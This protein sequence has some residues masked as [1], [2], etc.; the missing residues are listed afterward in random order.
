MNT[1]QN[2]VLGTITQDHASDIA[3]VFGEKVASMVSDNDKPTT[4]LDLLVKSGAFD[5]KS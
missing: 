1:T 3:E 4:F 2:T 5:V